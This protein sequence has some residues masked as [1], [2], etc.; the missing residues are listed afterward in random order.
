ME[1]DKKVEEFEKRVEEFRKKEEE[2]ERK[3]E[4]FDKKLELEKKVE[5]HEE[6]QYLNEIRNILANGVEKLDR[7]NVGTLSVFG[8]MH[9]YSLRDSFP[10]LTTKRVFWKGVVL[11][12]LWFIKG[13]T[14]TKILSEQGVK[15]WDGNSSREFLDSRG[16]VHREVGDI[17]PAYGWNWRHFGAKYVDCNTDYTGH[18]VDQ[19]MEC[20]RLLKHNKS[21]RRIILTAWDPSK[22]DELA[23]PAC[24]AFV[25]FYVGA[26]DELSCLLSQRANDICLGVPFNIASYSLLTYII[27]HHCGLVPGEFIHSM[28]DTHIYLNHIE[29]VKKQL[30]RTPRP[31]PKLKIKCDPKPIDEYTFEDF[32]LID[33]N[34][35]PIIKMEMAV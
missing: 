19:L 35:H 34:P 31:F 9:R 8:R 10:L 30:D 14:N 11:E 17:G 26:N 25:Q 12:L 27:A 21:S 32:E 24:H 5:E 13:Q 18:G 6:Y 33:Y 15:I 4:E 23:L 1:F 3:C 2:F 22:L 28:G 29:P 20:I 7:T 16:L